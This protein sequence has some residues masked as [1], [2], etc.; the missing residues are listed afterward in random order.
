MALSVVIP[1]ELASQALR[2]KEMELHPSYWL[3]MQHKIYL[4]HL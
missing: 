3:G 2:I 1:E 4:M